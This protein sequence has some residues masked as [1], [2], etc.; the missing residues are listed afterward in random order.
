MSTPPPNAIRRVVIANKN[1]R[2][3]V[4]NDTRTVGTF[5]H[6]PGF[7]NTLI[8]CT[9]STPLVGETV[10]V[11][12]PVHP[13]VN[14]L[15]EIGGTSFMIVTFPPDA[16]MADPAFNGL[17]FGEEVSR[18]VPGLAQTFEQEDPVMHTTDT[19]DYGVVLDGEIWLDLGTGEE[20][21]LNKHDIVIQNG[22][23]HGWRNKSHA[24]VTMLFVLIGAKRQPLA[25]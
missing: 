3:T 25:T 9:P 20:V 8:W 11:K 10:H 24:P 7:A 13:T 4:V 2:P 18:K 15:P 5:E 23:R 6:L 21:H 19:V 1:N 12:D 16:T 22:C 14:F 17:A